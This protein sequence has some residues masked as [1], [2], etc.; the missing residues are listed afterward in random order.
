MKYPGLKFD[1][2]EAGLLI[3]LLSEH[4]EYSSHMM[5]L[6]EFQGDSYGIAMWEEQIGLCNGLLEFVHDNEEGF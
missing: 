5:S 2:D 3:Q 6:S 1:S 4:R